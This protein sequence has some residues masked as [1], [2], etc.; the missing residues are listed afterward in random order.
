MV[1]LGDGLKLPSP[2][3]S[4]HNQLALSLPHACELSIQKSWEI[5]ELY[6]LNP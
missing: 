3:G 1:A 2:N 6:N 5:D 4:K